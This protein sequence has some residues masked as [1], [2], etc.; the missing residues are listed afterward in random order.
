M[1]PRGWVGCAADAG[2]AREL[3]DDE[4]LVLALPLDPN[5]ASD[6]ALS[7]LPGLG[8]SL[9]RA[10]VAYRAANG[11]F[12]DVEDLARVPGIGPRRLARARAALEIRPPP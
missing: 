4:R 5:R 7:H 2:P 6:S 9:A 3:T 8:P 11:P 12:G 10:I 1:P